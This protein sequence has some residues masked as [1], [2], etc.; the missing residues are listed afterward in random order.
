MSI[1]FVD[2]KEYETSLKGLFIM[3]DSELENLVF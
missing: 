2:G 3:C 1:Y